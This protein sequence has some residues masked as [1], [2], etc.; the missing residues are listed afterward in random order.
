MTY[1]DNL[2]LPHMTFCNANLVRK[3]Y[4]EE[5]PIMRRLLF[6]WDFSMWSEPLYYFDNNVTLYEHIMNMSLDG[7]DARQML[8]DASHQL[9]NMVHKMSM[10]HLLLNISEYFT[11]IYTIMGMCYTLNGSKINVQDPGLFSSLELI[12][13]VEQSE[14]RFGGYMIPNIGI[15]VCIVQF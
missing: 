10:D 3:S 8:K 12:L 2:T 4:A 11:P 5:N 15:W 6:E 9:E 14:F 1:H 13:N 7:V